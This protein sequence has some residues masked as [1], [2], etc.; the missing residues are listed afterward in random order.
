MTIAA[1]NWG[2]QARIGIF[3]VASEP[4]PEAEWWAMTPAGVSVHAARVTAPT[5]WAR[6]D[7]ARTTVTLEP[8]L[9]RG[10]RQFAAMRLNAITIAH[11]SSSIAGGA[12]W[13]QAVS[14]RLAEI[15]PAG[16]AVT[17]NGRDCQA[18][19]RAGN[20]ARPFLVFPAW[21]QDTALPAGVAYF[22]EHGF[23]PAGHMRVDPGRKW[24]D[25]A[26]GELYP[27]GMAF[28]QDVE[29]L[30]RQ[31]STRCPAEA[32]GVLMVGTGLRAVGIIDALERDLGRPVLSA[33]QASLW[34]CLA[35]SGVTAAVEGYGRLLRGA[36][37]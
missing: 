2:W 13:D 15:L 32:D 22:A 1:D 29:D 4:I 36:G 18:A 8:D 37:R 20:V 19:L 6:W 26:P 5:P 25:L 3:I 28:E 31:V 14:K 24:R 23:K 11:S 7:A 12:G 21:F 27:Q 35:L 17:T 9:E 30:Y 10:A 33:N 16:T 34:N